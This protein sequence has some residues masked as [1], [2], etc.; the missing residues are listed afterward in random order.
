MS[1]ALG[2][3]DEFHSKINSSFKWWTLLASSWIL[4][5]SASKSQSFAW[6]IFDWIR[7]NQ[8]QTNRSDWTNTNSCFHR[9][10]SKAT[11]LTLTSNIYSRRCLESSPLNVIDCCISSHPKLLFL[12]KTCAVID[13]T[14]CGYASSVSIL[15]ISRK[16]LLSY[17]SIKKVLGVSPIWLCHSNLWLACNS[18]IHTSLH[19][20]QF[21]WIWTLVTCNVNIGSLTNLTWRGHTSHLPYN[22]AQS[23]LEDIIVICDN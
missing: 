16:F 2:H 11:C 14:S 7:C 15:K 18:D 17:A 4:M 3:L 10:Y 21:L 22:F 13:C 6:K 20:C 23:A 12:V 1:N 8:F 9:Q 19:N 5:L